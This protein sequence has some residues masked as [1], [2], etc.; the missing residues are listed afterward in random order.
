MQQADGRAG[1]VVGGAGGPGR[2]QGGVLAGL[3]FVSGFAALVYQVLWVR[4]LGLL[5]GSTAQ[6]AALA[7]AIFFAGIALGG[8]FWGRRAAA[9]PS[10]LRGFGLLEL[11]VAAT[12]LG[13][14]VLLDAYVALYPAIHAIVGGTPALETLAKAVIATVVL[15][16]PAFLMGG[17]LPLM[18]QHL[19][20]ARD[21]LGR[22]GSAL[23][24]VNTA[25]SA[26]G[27]LAAGFVLPL[28]LGFTGAYLLAVGLDLAVGLGAVA[29][30]R[31]AAVGAAS[32]TGR[33]DP[34]AQGQA[35]AVG[36]G[37]AP[38]VRAA[39]AAA[40]AVVWRPAGLPVSLVWVLAFASG[41]ATLGIEVVWT[42]LFA[43]VL[44]N[45]AYTYALVLSAFLL[46]LALGA[47]AANALA[48]LGRPRPDRVL[49]VLL[50]AAA[51]VAATS[52]WLFYEVTDGMAYVGRD[53]AW[54]GYLLAV[55]GVAAV[56]VLLPGIV[57]GAVLPYLLRVLEA[58]ERAPGELVGRLVAANTAGGIAG[59]LLTGFVLLP[60]VGAWRSL[61][62]LAVVYP[63]LVAALSLLE[64]TPARLAAATAAAALAV[65]LLVT[66][67]TLDAV[68]LNEARGEE[69]VEVRE[70]PEAHVAVIGI[71]DDRILRVN[72]FYTLG[73]SRAAHS[74]RNQTVL[75][76]LLH[77][78]PSS[79][80]YLGMGT[81]I[82]AG[83][84]LPFPVERVVVCELLADVVDAAERH[85][86]PWTEGLFTDP[87]VEVHAEDGR[88]CLRRSDERFDLV[89]SDL[90]TPWKAGTANL[91]TLEHFETA[92]Q[93]LEPGGRFV[94]WL[95]LYQISDTELGIIARTMDEAFEQVTLWRGDLYPRRSIVALVGQAD[96][97]P[98]EPGAI[99]EQGRAAAGVGGLDDADVEALALR[100]Y[101]GN[102]T[103]TGLFADRPLNTDARPRIEHLAP[104][105]H[106]EARA[107]GDAAFL[108]GE[109]REDLYLAL[110]TA[111]PV[112]EDP[113]L[114]AL[115][116]DQRG[117]VHAGHSYSRHALLDDLGRPDLAAPYYAEFLERSPQTSV[118]DLSPARRLLSRPTGLLRR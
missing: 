73:S 93:R 2:R 5:F 94:Q 84:A 8:W 56:V 55:A 113:F 61:L 3:F 1:D 45:S 86:A 71:D 42:R 101:V 32:T 75:P 53:L 11:G 80:F 97:A 87:R 100:H 20:R 26:T 78:E 43:Q 19:V 21:E 4:E 90:F 102:V 95:P 111:L 117:Y 85:F 14:F 98:L 13:H 63:L 51:A 24:A 37:E 103:A 118:D 12:A 54:S 22:T 96:D 7:I 77:R 88:T 116:E 23:Y 115:D 76:L 104:R 58:S 69:L 92:R 105:T 46:A 52:P 18:A 59:S 67:P 10:P 36:A 31:R 47:S 50:L 66:T 25:G 27:A 62:L 40:A 6:A 68:R 109:E 83:A 91:Y 72:N 9:S 17:T 35:T 57:L 114:A 79:V 60:L 33:G 39:P 82:T 106:R 16:P 99:A 44:Q 28:A 48:R 81:G 65:P 49:G 15:L 89:I 74:E 34:T 64:L 108:V 38:A 70:G 107:G 30:A 112:E 110:R 29:L 41:V